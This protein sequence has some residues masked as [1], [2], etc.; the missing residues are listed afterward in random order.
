M[1]NFFGFGLNSKIK[2]PTI[3]VAMMA[4]CPSVCQSNA[5]RKHEIYKLG[6]CI[7]FP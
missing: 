5:A 3:G 6:I 7:H 2:L 1:Y 4:D